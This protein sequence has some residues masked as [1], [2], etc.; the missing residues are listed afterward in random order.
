MIIQD[1]EVL[2]N[3]FNQQAGNIKEQLTTLLVMVSD[4][5]V[6]PE[7]AISSFNAEL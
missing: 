7:E 3:A 5:R 6:P 4:G 2:L 1:I